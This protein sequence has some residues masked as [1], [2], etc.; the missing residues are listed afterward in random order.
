M[1]P[2]PFR[3]HDPTSLEEALD[4]VATLDNAKL[5]AGGQSLM[6]MLN[7][8]LAFP[9]DVVDLNRIESLAHV[10]ES[11]NGISIGAMTRQRALERSALIGRACPL[12]HEA[13]AQVGHRQ[14]RSR[15]TIG[16][17]LCHLDPSA[18][19]PVA[20]AALGA[21]IHV[22]RRGGSRSLPMSE[23]PAFYMTPAIEPDEIVTAIDFEPW[24]A[25]H[26]Y[27]FVEFAR[28]LGDFAVTGVAV[29]L[30][31]DGDGIIRRASIALGGVGEGPIRCPDAEAAI[32]GA[33]A[34]DDRFDE[35][36]R[37][38]GEI[39]AMGMCTHR[40]PIAATWPACCPGAPSP[41]HWSARRAK[42][43]EESA[44]MKDTRSIALV[45]NGVRHEV[46]VETRMTLADCLRH[47]LR[48]TGTHLGCEHGVCGACT[49]IVDGQ[50]VRS[51]LMLA[52]QA[53][54]AE[55]TT[56]E[57]ISGAGGALHPLQEAFRDRHGLQCGF[58]TPGML[59]TLMEFLD[60]N[61]APSE[62]EVREAIS[63]NLCR[64]TG[65]QGIVA[66]ALDAA[67]RLRGSDQAPADARPT[68][69]E[70]VGTEAKP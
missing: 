46:E 24:P 57:G 60:E 34:N 11:G 10:S 70:S 44:A 2:P 3:Y 33:E 13:L 55:V 36:A 37:I 42:R 35:A 28:R 1:K 26:G 4:L 18:E 66:A 12:L 47:R 62:T 21:T 40:P 9:D 6:P 20:A 61:P 25:G 14:T 5:L 56:V 23:F 17:S 22:S 43:D 54:R 15:G 59:M 31:I 64:C 29:L 58:C 41:V 32:S 48:L 45:V 30:D 63:G 49:V 65:Y 38:C 67:T 69:V 7:L 39:E 8:R 16:G 53:E 52:V 68:G 27:A 50:A 19:L 51:C